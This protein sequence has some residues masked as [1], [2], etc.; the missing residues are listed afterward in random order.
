[1]TYLAVGVEHH[2]A[3]LAV[4]ERLAL[5]EDEARALCALL[6][7]EPSID[8]A[9]VLSTCNRTELYLVAQD[10]DDAANAAIGHLTGRDPELAEHIQHWPE[11][12]AAEHLFR[13]A[14]GLESQ[15]AG[16]AQI[17]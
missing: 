16:E 12:A 1:M 2:S 9:A 8:E 7:A 5:S 15:V 3:P 6:A 10:R 11:M 17:L 4:R 14:A 13:V